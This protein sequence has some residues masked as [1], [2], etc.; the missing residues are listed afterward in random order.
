MQLKSLGD[1]YSKLLAPFGSTCS[2][3]DT[4]FMVS[5]WNRDRAKLDYLHKANKSTQQQ[6]NKISTYMLLIAAL[7]PKGFLR[8]GCINLVTVG[9]MKIGIKV[10]LGPNWSVGAVQN[11]AN[12]PFPLGMA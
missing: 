6:E 2:I 4:A 11:R 8:G 3:T 9:W 10:L 1:R 12:L 5:V 7:I